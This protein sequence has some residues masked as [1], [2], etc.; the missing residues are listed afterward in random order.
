MALAIKQRFFAAHSAETPSLGP[1]IRPLSFRYEGR[2]IYEGGEAKV[3]FYQR[4]AELPRPTKILLALSLVVLSLGMFWLFMD[5]DRAL[6]WAPRLGSATILL[7][8][9]SGWTCV[10]ALATYWANQY[11]APV[12]LLAFLWI[13]LL[14]PYSDNHPVRTIPAASPPREMLDDRL[15]HWLGRRA[16]AIALQPG[17]KE[18]PV[19]IVAAE[20]GGIRAAYWTA[21]V[22]ARIEKAYPGFASHV[23]VVS[24]VSGGGL[25]GALF[26]ALLAEEQEHR[27]RYCVAQ[28]DILACAQT[29]LRH[30]FLAPTFATMLYPDL[31]QRFLPALPFSENW[32]RGT[33][34][35]AALE[36]AW[37]DIADRTGGNPFRE[38]FERLWD[39]ERR[40]PLPSLVLNS[41]AVED[42]KRVLLSDFRMNQ[43]ARTCLQATSGLPFHDVLDLDEALNLPPCPGAG[44]EQEPVLDRKTMRLSTAV[45]NSSRF[46]YVSPAGKVS[47]G[48]HIVDG[49]YF[50]NSGTTAA[51]ELVQAI[52]EFGKKNGRPLTPVV[53][54]LQSSPQGPEG[55]G[56]RGRSDIA[57]MMEYMGKAKQLY[58]SETLMPVRAI[59][60]A[61][62]G[63][64]S[65]AVNWL[66]LDLKLNEAYPKRFFSFS[67]VGQPNEFPLGWTLSE[68]TWVK[69]D[70]QVENFFF[71]SQCTPSSPDPR[72]VYDFFLACWPD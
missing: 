11:R 6:V 28:T 21:S 56:T 48:L 71:G 43:K 37:D 42:G 69:M 65:F 7:L 26:D 16:E 8:A 51:A 2:E 12:F 67:V 20:G 45:H 34:L 70:R 36:R 22:L 29:M 10:G 30:D 19:F 40:G 4:F 64:G 59:F 66:Q 58:L 24:G 62:L 38:A 14:N 41:M 32:D 49:G 46:S 18:P 53:I 9:A 27:G 63:R 54:Y 1:P 23:F 3:V 55:A 15:E 33:T 61:G 68:G 44:A 72:Q 25:G 50:E 17:D 5:R 39:K 60:N 47:S 57:A 52:E 31:L 35:E 13:A